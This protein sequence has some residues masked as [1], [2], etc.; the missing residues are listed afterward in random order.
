M[1]QALKS[2]IISVVSKIFVLQFRSECDIISK[3]PFYTRVVNSIRTQNGSDV[4]KGGFRLT[5]GVCAKVN[6]K[7]ISAYCETENGFDALLSAELIEPFVTRAIELLDEPAFFFLEL[8][9]N[10]DEEDIENYDIYYLDNCTLPVIRAIMKRYGELLVQDGISRFGFGAH[11][12]GVEIYLQSYQQV[13]IYYPEKTKA[14]DIFEE[15]GAAKTDKLVTLW[16]DFSQED[17]GISVRVELNG[18]SV[19]DIPENL[20]SAGMYLYQE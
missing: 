17:P 11:D 9:K 13:S 16:D 19:F 3:I 4:M 10:A 1:Y 2:K 7:L 20:K 15:L 5:E 12:S 8:P 6:D 18:E 14:A